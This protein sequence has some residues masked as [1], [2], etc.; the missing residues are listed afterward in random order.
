M[1]QSIYQVKFNLQ[2]K[3]FK[4][5]IISGIVMADTQPEAVFEAK[6]QLEESVKEH[7]YSIKLY[8]ACKLQKDFFFMVP[9]KAEEVKTE[10]VVEEATEEIVEVKKA[11][12]AKVQSKKL[13]K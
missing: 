6:L 9:T 3:G 4:S 7:S 12:K 5:F 10:E 8:S 2:K 13:I 11:T 1:T